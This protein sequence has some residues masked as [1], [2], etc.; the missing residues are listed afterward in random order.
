[1]LATRDQENLVAR[2]QSGAVLKQQQ[3]NQLG[4]RYPKTPIKIPLNDENAGHMKGAKSILGNRTKGNENAMASKGSK[5]LDKSNFVTP[6][7]PRN[8]AVLG[9]KTTN[10]KAG[11]L[12]P[13]NVKS[14]VKQIEKS[15]TNAPNTIK[16]KQK[17]PQAEIQKLQ[18]HAEETD[19]LSEEEPEYCPPRPKDLPYESDVFPDGVLTFEGLKPENRLK[20]FYQYYA[21]PID[22]NGVSK[23]ERELAEKT[24][25]ALE[26]GDRKIKEDIENFQWT[27]IQDELDEAGTVKPAASAAGPVKA[28]DGRVTPVVRKPLGTLTSRTA[29]T[30]LSMDDATKSMQRK[31]T[32]AVLAPIAKKK[33]A[34]FAIPRFTGAK[35]AVPLP[36]TARRTPMANIEANSRTTLGY[37]KGR[38][39][40]SVLASGTTKPAVRRAQGPFK[41]KASGLPRSETTSSTDSDMTITPAR[42]ANKKTSV[43]T[44]D[45]L[46]KERVP[47]LSIFHPE[48]EGDDDGCDFA[49]GPPPELEDDEFEMQLPE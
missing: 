48:D 14:T 19:P 6:M 13:V 3:N 25:K 39:A 49:G 18:V 10:A 34:S 45:Q 31:S 41:P 38:A 17:Q 40:A 23:S 16:P 29:A 30:T 8:R 22:E 7:Q 5:G 28:K 26:E 37:N 33:T 20:G 32:K 12:Q 2:H 47:F 27:S 44:E 21:D 11:G 43:S 15:Q 4:A 42:F 35:S 46:W 9:D 36:T 24:R 1:M